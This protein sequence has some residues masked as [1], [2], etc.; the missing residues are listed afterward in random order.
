MECKG[1]LIGEGAVGVGSGVL[2]HIIL[3]EQRPHIER[4]ETAR[5]IEG[6]ADGASIEQET[7][8]ARGCHPCL[9]YDLFPM[10]PGW[11]RRRV[12]EPEAFFIH[13]SKSATV[14]KPQ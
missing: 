2:L 1:A 13:P 5:H 11:T 8:A 14:R 7:A 4:A 12:A 3:R 10:S 9:R 6:A